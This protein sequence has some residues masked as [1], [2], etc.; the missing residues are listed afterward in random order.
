M[1]KV[2]QTKIDPHVGDC[3][4]ACVASIFEL[5]IDA[6]PNFMEL[7]HR[8]I[9]N[10]FQAYYY[11]I[12]WL[13]YELHIEADLSKIEK[14][15]GID[16][17]FVA[18]VKSNIFDNTYHSVIID[19]SLNVV[20]DPNPNCSGKDYEICS[21]DV[22]T[23]LSKLK[24]PTPMLVRNKVA[25]VLAEYL[26]TEREQYQVSFKPVNAYTLEITDRILSIVY[27][28]TTEE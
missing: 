12:R 16:G 27:G 5:P 17:L 11:Y 19:K 22:F 2:M 21:F 14:Y 4:R 10:W 18:T 25:K 3:L 24:L 9:I 26:F 28:V 23:P 1:I 13:G 8:N 20:H 15:G 7:S 6:V